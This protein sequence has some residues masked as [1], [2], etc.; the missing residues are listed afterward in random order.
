M[1]RAARKHPKKLGKLHAVLRRLL[2][3]RRSNAAHDKG[4]VLFDLVNILGNQKR[5][6]RRLRAIGQLP[7]TPAEMVRPVHGFFCKL[8]ALFHPDNLAAKIRRHEK[9]L[10]IALAVFLSQNLNAIAVQRQ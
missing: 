9:E 4:V 3:K 6:L 5:L 8:R 2:F 1:L 7:Q 10:L